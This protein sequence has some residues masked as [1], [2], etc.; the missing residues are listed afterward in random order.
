MH[1]ADAAVL[2]ELMRLRPGRP[3]TSS[4]TDDLWRDPHAEQRAALEAQIAAARREV[5]ANNRL[6]RL[7][8]LEG[9]PG[10][11]AID[12]FRRDQ[13]TLDRRIKDA[14]GQLEALPRSAVDPITIRELHAA[15]AGADLAQEIA[16]AQERGDTLALRR[17]V[18]ETVQS[19]I[20]T[21]RVAGARNGKTGW[22]RAQVQWTPQVDLLLG[23][24]YLLLDPQAHAEATA[25]TSAAV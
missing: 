9:D 20:V 23:H 1:L 12:A 5:E 6:L 18:G 4:A 13:Q 22:V 24:G 7:L 14:L 17:L 2:R 3:W 11:E 10:Q 16:R 8:A 19:A 25:A 21:E 15:L